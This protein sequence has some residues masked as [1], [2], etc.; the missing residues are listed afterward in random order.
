MT[1][2]E[3]KV[4]LGGDGGDELFGGYDR[5]A[6]DRCWTRTGGP[7]SC[8]TWWPTRCCSGCPTSSPSEPDHKLRWVDLMARKTG[9]ERYAES[10]Q[11]FW[12]N[13]ARRADCT[14]RGSGEARGAAAGD[15]SA[16]P[17]RHRNAT[18]AVDRMMYWTSCPG[19]RGSR[20]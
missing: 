15:L 11:Y 18:E 9:G 7:A 14:R 5:Y 1:A 19:C 2:R 16:R 12:F 6:A 10:L 8:A 20:S 13:E 17:E 3:V 4:V